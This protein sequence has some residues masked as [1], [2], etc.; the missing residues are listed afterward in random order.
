MIPHD[1]SSV[2]PLIG[3]TIFPP[4]DT[5]LLVPNSTPSVSVV[6]N[7]TAMDWLTTVIL[8]VVVIMDRNVAGIG[9]CPCTGLVNGLTTPMSVVRAI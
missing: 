3:C 7:M 1:S 4:R 2:F 9:P 5:N 6:T 8:H